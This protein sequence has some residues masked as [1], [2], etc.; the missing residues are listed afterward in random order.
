MMDDVLVDSDKIAGMF[1]SLLFKVVCVSAS[2]LP[3]DITFGSNDFC[4]MDL[5]LRQLDLLFCFFPTWLGLR[6]AYALGSWH[7]FD[8][9]ALSFDVLNVLFVV[10]DQMSIIVS[11]LVLFLSQSYHF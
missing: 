5:T 10:T 8:A 1:V 9:F 6:L 4:N 3:S 11:D 7:Q 2:D